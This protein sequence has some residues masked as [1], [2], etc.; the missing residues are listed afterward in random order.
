MILSELKRYLSERGM[1]TL[2]DMAIHFDMEPDAVCGVLEHWI[3]KGKVR[4]HSE[5]V[6]KCKTC[7]KCDPAMI[8]V[9]EWVG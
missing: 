8:E 3:R 7:V 1:A 6:V 5:P 2:N 9:Y 4:K